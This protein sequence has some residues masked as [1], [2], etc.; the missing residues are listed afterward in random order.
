LLSCIALSHQFHEWLH[1]RQGLPTGSL[2]TASG[3]QPFRNL[4]LPQQTRKAFAADLPRSTVIVC[5]V[6]GFPE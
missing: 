4:D 6:A 5:A 2:S 3:G 1:D